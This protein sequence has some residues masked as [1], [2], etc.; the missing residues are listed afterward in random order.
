MSAIDLGGR[1][2]RGPERRPGGAPVSGRGPR[3][4]RGSDHRPWTLRCLLVAA[5]LLGALSPEAAH[6]YSPPPIKH[7]FVLIDENESASTT[8]A[9]GSPAP[10]LSQTLVERGAYLPDYY[11]IGHASLD[12]YISMVSGQAP[13]PLTSTDCPSFVDFPAG[14]LDSSGQEN[15]EGCVYPADVPSLMSQF[16]AAGLTWRAYEDGMGAD[17]NRESATCGHPPVGA[18]DDTQTPTAVDQY[19]TRHDPFVY[20]HYVIDN[21]VECNANVVNLNRLQSDLQSAATTPNYIFLTPDLCDD[22]HYST[23]PDGRPGGLAQADSFL[24]TWVPI[25]T[26]SAAFKQN[27]LLIITFDEA[28]GDASA[29]CNEVPGPYEAANSLLPGVTGPGGGDIGAVL[30]SPFIAAGTSSTAGYNHYSML[31]SIEDL[32]GLPRIGEAAG[33]AAFGSDVYTQP[34]GPEGAGGTGTGS[35]ASA[36]GSGAGETTANGRETTRSADQRTG[37]Q[38][39]HGGATHG[40]PRVSAAQLTAIIRR[41]ITPSPRAASIAQLVEHRG[42]SLRFRAPE[43]GRAVVRWYGAPAGPRLP[44]SWRFRPS[45]VLLAS[46]QTAFPSP[47]TRTIVLRFTREGGQLLRRA[48]RLAL[49]AKGMFTAIGG[50]PVSTRK[51][52][53]LRA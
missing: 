16:D 20:F 29:C 44:E 51:T 53:A 11:G 33:A 2:R 21:P 1:G 17:P 36:G 19:T 31:A 10:Y 7:V 6:A 32:F 50:R 13:N 35:G 15:N 24:K 45:P 23:C 41:Q 14:S 25:I 40:T 48:T 46:G 34:N 18:A 27:G 4:R 8:F 5:L 42:F 30:L 38:P 22:G 26:S 47:G 28:V 52:F 12:N 49:T 37:A 39:A 43:A 9:A 3:A